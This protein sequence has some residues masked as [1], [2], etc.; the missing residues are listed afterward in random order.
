MSF[1]LTRSLRTVLN[2]CI[3]LAASQL[4]LLAYYVFWNLCE[5]VAAW[6]HQPLSRL[7]KILRS[8]LSYI[9]TWHPELPKSRWRHLTST[10]FEKICFHFF[11][12]LYTSRTQ[13][14]NVQLFLTRNSSLFSWHHSTLK[15]KF[16]LE[17][18][19]E[20]IRAIY[21]SESVSV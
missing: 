3:L 19:L 2:E 20:K 8:F 9:K 18:D 17:A 12:S 6:R 14:K 15:A 21:V 13:P 4:W 1:F 5:R 7:G 16:T 11:L 10:D